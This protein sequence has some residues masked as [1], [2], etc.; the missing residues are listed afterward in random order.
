ME[1]EEAKANFWSPFQLSWW[2]R[3]GGSNSGR[4]EFRKPSMVP[5]LT[6]CVAPSCLCPSLG[7]RLLPL[8][9]LIR[10]C[11]YSFFA[12]FILYYSLAPWTGHSKSRALSSVPRTQCPQH[13]AQVWHRDN[14]SSNEW[15]NGWIHIF[16]L[17]EGVGWSRSPGPSLNPPHMPADLPHRGWTLACLPVSLC[18]CFLFFALQ[19]MPLFL[20][21]FMETENTSVVAP[22]GQ[23]RLSRC[24]IKMPLIFSFIHFSIFFY[25]HLWLFKLKAMMQRRGVDR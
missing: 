25:K 15:G 13:P 4:S 18:P 10:G 22:K 9:P 3:R 14:F 7:L 6:C 2:G 16:S 17:W 5:L 23:Q 11:K 8:Q 24:P 20:L 19:T 21:F 12:R 1:V